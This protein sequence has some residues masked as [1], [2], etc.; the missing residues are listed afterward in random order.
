Q[1]FRKWSKSCIC[2]QDA[3]RCSCGNNHNLGKELN[4]K[5]IVA[6]SSEIKENP[7]SRSAKLRLFQFKA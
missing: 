7:R 1:R 2:P 5:P 6:T 3:M 4:R